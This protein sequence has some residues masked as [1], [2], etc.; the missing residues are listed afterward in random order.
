[1]IN[2]RKALLVYALSFSMFGFADEFTSVKSPPPTADDASVSKY[3]KNLSA[4]LGYDVDTTPPTPYDVLLTYT[5]SLASAGQQILNG[6]FASIPVN[7]PYKNFSYNTAYDVF[8]SQANDILYKDYTSTDSSSGVSVVENFDQKTY[9]NDPVSQFLLNAIATPDWSNCESSSDNNCLS[10]DKVMTT[11]LQDVTTDSQLPTGYD[12]YKYA[13]SSKFL[14]QLNTNTL[15][16]PMIYE[17]DITP[18]TTQSGLPS[19]SQIQQA[20]DFIRYVSEEVIP[21]QTM[22]QEDYSTLYSLA[23]PPT[24]DNGNL[25]GDVDATNTM[26]AKVGLAKYLLGLRVYAAKLSVPVSNLYYILGKRIAQSTSNSSGQ[27]TVTSEALNEFKMA[28]WRQYDPSKKEDE[29]WA[30]TINSASAATVQKE[31]AILLSEISMQLYQSRQIQ[32]RILLTNSII[33]LQSIA[34]NKP[35]AGLP[36]DVNSDKNT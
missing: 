34:Q 35:D 32:E 20:Q 23:Y 36:S 14:S 16:A 12:Y 31:M 6:I 24:D 10:V 26:N 8:N 19:G 21:F 27:E 33:L 25:I 13:N 1:M 17:K 28:T 30:Q 11:V 3:I 2:M 29:Q 4:Y 5:L 18:N 15:I 7:Y 9:Q 22:T